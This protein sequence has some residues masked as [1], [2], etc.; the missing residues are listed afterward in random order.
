MT[1]FDDTGP[2][3]EQVLRVPWYLLQFAMG[4]KHQAPVLII[5]LGFEYEIHLLFELEMTK[6]LIKPWQALVL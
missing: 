3:L 2:L 1:I 4:A 6:L 5:V